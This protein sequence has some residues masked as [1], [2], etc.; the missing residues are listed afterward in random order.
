MFG[1]PY[2]KHG[3]TEDHN[4]MVDTMSHEIEVVRERRKGVYV[5]ELSRHKLFSLI[6]G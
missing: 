4:V 2:I 1:A 3:G 6:F 5:T